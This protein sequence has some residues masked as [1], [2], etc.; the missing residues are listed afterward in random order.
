MNVAID[1]TTVIGTNILNLTIVDPD[2]DT[3]LNLGILIG[4]LRNAFIF[5]LLSDNSDNAT[6][7]QYEAIGQLTV[8]SPLD[9]E[10]TSVYALILFAYDSKN[11]ANINVTIELKPNNTKAPYFQLMPGF[12]SYQ[13]RVNE[14][15]TPPVIDGPIVSCYIT[16]Y[17]GR[18]KL[19][20]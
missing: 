6:R 17:K 8:V 9:Y 11:P 7:T 3:N 16:T 19:K 2:I 1:E 10:L 12:T 4:N 14:E 20:R 18:F 15:D 13:Y 5:T